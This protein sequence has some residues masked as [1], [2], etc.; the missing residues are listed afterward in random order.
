[1]DKF[2]LSYPQIKAWIHGHIHHSSDYYIGDKRIIC[3][4]FKAIFFE[5]SK[6]NKNW[7]P[8]L[9]IQIP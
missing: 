3:N 1:M 6:V 5:D 9:N 4:P 7:N 8:R 2:I